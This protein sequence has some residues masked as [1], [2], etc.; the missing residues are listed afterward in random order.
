MLEQS[1]VK[2]KYFLLIGLLFLGGMLPYTTTATANTLD[3]KSLIKAARKDD[4]ETVKLH[5][6]AGVDINTTKGFQKWTALMYASWHGNIEMAELLIR[7]GADVN[8]KGSAEGVTALMLASW[9]TPYGFI[10]TLAYGLGISV[11]NEVYANQRKQKKVIVKLLIEAEADVN[12]KDDDEWTALMYASLSERKETV[13]LLLDAGANV[14]A[15]NDDEETA[16]NIA[17]EEGFAEIAELL[18]AAG[19]K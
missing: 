5:I 6:E 1:R 17:N 7:A 9:K 4:E 10:S 11:D 13:K 12:A 18:I 8:T 3:E 15:I 19:A 16:L 14:N 2:M